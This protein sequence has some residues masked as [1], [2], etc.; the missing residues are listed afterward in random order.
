MSG[1][2]T[3]RGRIVGL[4][5]DGSA[6]IHDGIVLLVL[7]SIVAMATAAI[8]DR[9]V[10]AP[11]TILILVLLDGLAG[12]GLMVFEWNSLSGRIAGL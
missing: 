4:A 7:G 10:R 11:Q 1:V 8:H 2:G 3:L 5:R 9:R 12:L 6:G